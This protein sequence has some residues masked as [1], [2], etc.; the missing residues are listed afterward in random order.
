MWALYCGY[1]N[2]QQVLGPKLNCVPLCPEPLFLP[3][4]T[5][6]KIDSIIHK[7]VE[8][9]LLKSL[10]STLT[11]DSTLYGAQWLFIPSKVCESR[12]MSKLKNR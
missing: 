11:H 9:L 5:Q 12:C 6:E 2:I 8:D 10:T 7:L 4:K 1:I 3:I